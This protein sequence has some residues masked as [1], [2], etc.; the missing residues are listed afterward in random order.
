MHGLC[1][2]ILVFY[3]GRSSLLTSSLSALQNLISALPVEVW[4]GPAHLMSMWSILFSL[5]ERGC[6]DAGAVS[7]VLVALLHQ[8]VA[9][10]PGM[11]R[12]QG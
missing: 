7:S 12:T 9:M 11:V 10:E 5:L 6:E 3:R 1:D 2:L 4:G 8:T